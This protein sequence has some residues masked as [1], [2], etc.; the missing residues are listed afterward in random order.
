VKPK[1]FIE[2]LELIDSGQI[3]E[4]LGKEVI[5]EFVASGKS[6]REIVEEKKLKVLKREE[7]LEKVVEK[8]V[9][10]NGKVVEDYKKGNGKALNFL[11]GLV[12]KETEMKADPKK[13]KELILRLIQ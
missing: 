12:L 1:T 4:R 6:P 5:K 8:V 2:L 9:K 3:T 13:V 10:G 11:I 7:E